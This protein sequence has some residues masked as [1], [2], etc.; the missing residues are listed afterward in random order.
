[1]TLVSST[2]HCPLSLYVLTGFEYLADEYYL[3]EATSREL[4]RLRKDELVRLYSTA[5]LSEDPEHL[6]KPDLVQAIIA[7]RD[8]VASVPPSSPS[9]FTS[10]DG[11]SDD[12][13][14]QI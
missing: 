14:C 5:G 2:I 7:A 11:S 10:S 12:G 8:D 9:G 3:N 6:T 13:H 4:L 1:M